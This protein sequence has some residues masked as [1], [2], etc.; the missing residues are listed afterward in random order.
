MKTPKS[1]RELEALTPAD[2]LK[3]RRFTQ[4]LAWAVHLGATGSTSGFDRRNE[5]LLEAF[6]YLLYRDADDPYQCVVL[7]SMAHHWIKSHPA[8]GHEMWLCAIQR[9]GRYPK[10]NLK[11]S[12]FHAWYASRCEDIGDLKLAEFH[13]RKAVE[14]FDRLDETDR[15]DAEN[16]HN[17]LRG[18]LDKKAGAA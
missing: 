7:T 9:A 15:V 17:M 4:A 3:D 14:Y 10:A 12:N 13:Y 6:S 18:M 8:S 1:F 11:R 2:F 16:P 5:F